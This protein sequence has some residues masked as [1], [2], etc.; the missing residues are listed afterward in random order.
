MQISTD[1][2]LNTLSPDSFLKLFVTQ[3]KHQDPTEPLD[4]SQMTAEL[5][6]LASLQQLQQLNASFSS[7]LSLEKLHLAEQF[8]GKEVVYVSEGAY[9]T[10]T[11]DSAA[12]EGDEVGVYIGQTFVPVGD[13]RQVL[14]ESTNSADLA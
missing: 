10:G 7:V 3:M 1:S 4:P 14:G 5:A 2:M 12:L 11:V 9:R 13:I 6:Q 8:I